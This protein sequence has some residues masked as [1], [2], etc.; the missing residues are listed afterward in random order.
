MKRFS[1]LINAISTIGLLTV[2][3]CGPIIVPMG[4]QLTSDQ[5]KVVDESWQRAIVADEELGRQGWLDLM[6]R[7]FA[8]EYGVDRFHFTSEKQ[9]DDRLVTME[10]WFDR[11]R[12]DDDAFEVT[13]F[14]AERKILRKERYSRAD[15]EESIAAMYPQV[16]IQPADGIVTDEWKKEE[17]RRVARRARVQR[18]F[19]EPKRPDWMDVSEPPADAL[20][21]INVKER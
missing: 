21:P 14:D 4:H 9:V 1:H 19:P 18:I 7:S 20:A 12:P 8:F 11:E 17:E 6:V 10:V 16:R 15:V 13:M 2:V 3:A 5:Q